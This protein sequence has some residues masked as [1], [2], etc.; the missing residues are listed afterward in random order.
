MKKQKS[1]KKV[2][3]KSLKGLMNSI[4]TMFSVI[5]LI[6]LIKSFVSF[7]TLA[8]IFT[9]NSLVDTTMGAL[10]GSILAGNSINS[11]IIG[12]EMLTSGISLF[13]V[14]AFLVS[15]VT[16]GFVQIPAEKELLGTRFTATRNALSVVLA[17]AISLLTVWTMEVIG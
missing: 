15:W 16:V 4:P 1:L 9:Q 5:F 11:Y 3:M 17:I 2:F 14:T 12:N 8:T 13:A 7:D 10:I 6:G